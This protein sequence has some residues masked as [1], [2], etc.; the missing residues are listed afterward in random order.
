[1]INEVSKI[2]AITSENLPLLQKIL[3][4][5]NDQAVGMTYV[6][7]EPSDKEVP[8]GKLVVYDDG[9]NKNVYYRTG[10][11][12]V[13]SLALPSGIIAMWSGTVATIPAGW[14]LCDGNNSTPD[15]RDRFIVGA[16]QDSSGVA[17]TNVT[18]SLT[19]SG[20]GQIPAH[21][22]TYATYDAQGIGTGAFNGYSTNISNPSTAQAGSGT[23]N[24]AVYYALAFIMKT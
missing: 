22:H 1:M 5:I 24:I 15:L 11:D 14:V 4:D 12:D 23:K 16:T 18:G 6:T 2:P 7:S 17:K 13:G 19:Q 10:K 9:T 21:S 8:Y 3:S 20:D